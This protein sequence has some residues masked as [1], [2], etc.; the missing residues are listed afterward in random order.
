MQALRA[1]WAAAQKGGSGMSDL[2]TPDSIIQELDSIKNEVA[3]RA[4]DIEQSEQVFLKAKRD[5]DREYALAYRRADG[6]VEDRKQQAV[7]DADSCAQARDDA[8]TVLN[9][10]KQRSRD[11]DQGQSALQTQ[12]RLVEIT[13]RLAGIGER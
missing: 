13:Y 8:Q 6:P 7:L 9:Y 10:R 3:Q 11:L 4:R 2:K 1:R 5:Y 12:A